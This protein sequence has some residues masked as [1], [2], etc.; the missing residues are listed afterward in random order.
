LNV[1]LFSI[2][3]GLFLHP[4]SV[5]DPDRLF[6]V[7]ARHA[8]PQFGIVT[9]SVSPTEFRFLRDHATTIDL[10]SIDMV[11]FSLKGRPDGAPQRLVSDNY[12][13]VLQ[14]RI[15]VG[16]GF[17]PGENDRAH[18]TLVAVIGYRLWQDRFGGSQSVLGQMIRVNDMPVEIVGV[19]GPGAMERPMNGPPQIWMPLAA[20][21]PLAYAHHSPEEVHTRIAE[22][23][24][25]EDV[26]KYSD[27]GTD[28]VGRLRAGATETSAR[29]ELTLL[30]RQFR[31][32]RLD[33]TRQMTLTTTAAVGDPRF[34]ASL[35]PLLLVFLGSTL[36]LLLACANVGNLYLA[37][38]IARRGEITIRL[39]LGASRGRVVRQ[40][41]TEGLVLAI[42]ASTASVLLA[43]AFPALLRYALPPEWGPSWWPIGPDRTVL[44]VALALGVISC[45][46]SAL[47]PA[48]QGTRVIASG[49]YALKGGYARLRTTLLVAQV[50]LGMVLLLGAGLL[51][52]GIVHAG[53]LDLGFDVRGTTVMTIEWPG[54]YDAARVGAFETGLDEALRASGLTRIVAQSLAVPLNVGMETTVRRPEQNE[55]G[56]LYVSQNIVSDTFFDVLQIPRVAGQ[57][58]TPDTPNTDVVVNA[59][60]AAVL[61]PRQSP[62]GQTLI[63]GKKTLRV[64]GVVKDAFLVDLERVRPTIFM[65]GTASNL[66]VPTAATRTVEAV[67]TLVASLD[68]NATITV[69]PLAHQIHEQ[70]LATIAGAWI[71]GGL[72]LL[73]LLLASI[74]TFGVFS[75]FVIERTREIGVRMALGA[76]RADVLRMVT[77]H[78]A[79]A[80]AVGLFVGAGLSLGLGPVLQSY[81]YGLS[82]HDPV[83]YLGVIALLIVA[84]GTATALPAWRAVHVDPAITL[85]HE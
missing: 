59:T 82:P 7:R 79:R 27:W 78:A 1:G 16:R 8:D 51:M 19:A 60:L 39:G 9:S 30:D 83:A 58:F 84:A 73:A 62:L 21:I 69:S 45:L 55:Q 67:K 17:H 54:T 35:T 52:R 42:A 5:P 77:G 24:A 2:A 12:F 74:G 46:L 41:L 65:K 31:A 20:R 40:F 11:G 57:L 23:L 80:V 53:S 38:T 33:A 6:A 63:D 47:L 66:L 29:A 70:V 13:D 37:R 28:M 71:A 34:R 49:R 10:A 22:D 68:P 75:Y 3:N 85:R 43:A 72:G 14:F 36:L 18:P 25:G 61:W 26:N 56:H 50:A 44:A 32:E 15:V 81:L 76:S 4:W 64:I 48:L